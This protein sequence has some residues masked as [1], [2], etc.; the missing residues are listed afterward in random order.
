MG[1][2]PHFFNVESSRIIPNSGLQIWDGF[3]ASSL[4]YDNGFHLMI[5]DICKFMPTESC[6]GI[7]DDIYNTSETD[8]EYERRA[9]EKFVGRTVIT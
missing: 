7:L 2:N 1:R 9:I 3:K 4:Q 5:E 8:E 6:L